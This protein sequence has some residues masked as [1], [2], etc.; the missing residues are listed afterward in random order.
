MCMQE[1]SDRVIQVHFLKMF[2]MNVVG[3][4]RIY[5]LG[6]VHIFHTLTHF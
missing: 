5:L 1:M 2:Q 3:H 6:P 4:T